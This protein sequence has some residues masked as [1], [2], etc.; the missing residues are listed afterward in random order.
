MENKNIVF[1]HGSGM[2]KTTLVAIANEFDDIKIHL[3]DLP[4]HGDNKVN[5]KIED[6]SFEMYVD[7]VK[8]YIKDLE[9]VILIGHS[10]GGTIVL[11]ILSENLDNVL[12]GVTLCSS[13][14]YSLEEKFYKNLKNN[15][16]DMDY[17]SSNAGDLDNEDVL[18]ALKCVDEKLI[19]HDLLL[20]T[21]INIKDCLKNIKSKVLIVCGS[22]DLLAPS[23]D[24]IEMCNIIKNHRFISLKGM[25][26]SPIANKQ[27][28]ANNIRTYF[29]IED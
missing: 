7:Y 16:L 11:K 14:S 26:M 17:L 8:S 27:L 2:D 28:I 9:N 25:H 23:K 22:D 24:S 1:I 6:L 19:I 15:Y 3:I 5:S 12:G 13:F 20:C 21:T 4:N 10:L 29:N 18:E